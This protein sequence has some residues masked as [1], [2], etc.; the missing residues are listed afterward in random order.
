MDKGIY[1]ENSSTNTQIDKLFMDAKSAVGGL[2]QD[3]TLSECS[4]D[5]NADGSFLDKIRFSY[6][7]SGC[8]W[9]KPWD[10]IS[11]HLATLAY[12][13]LYPTIIIKEIQLDH[14]TLTSS[15]AHQASFG[16]KD[17]FTAKAKHE[18]A[19]YACSTHMVRQFILKLCH[20]YSKYAERGERKK[21]TFTKGSSCRY[22]IR[23]LWRCEMP[24]TSWKI[25][26]TWCNCMLIMLIE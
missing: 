7:V 12:Q 10:L 9:W 1:P 26:M 11:L 17:S 23:R 14:H 25:W 24:S 15:K 6:H 22:C 8:Y 18:D 13:Q 4:F 16:S 20:D 19:F 2:H 21:E 5:H 3:L